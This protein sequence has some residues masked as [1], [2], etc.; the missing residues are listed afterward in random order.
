MP[1]DPTR[2]IPVTNGGEGGAATARERKRESFRQSKSSAYGSDH[3]FDQIWLEE[4]D[5]GGGGDEFGQAN[6]GDAAER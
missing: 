3:S 5:G 1:R 4:D 6:Q 2:R